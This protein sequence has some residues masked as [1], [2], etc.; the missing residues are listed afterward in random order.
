MQIGKHLCSLLLISFFILLPFC[1]KIHIICSRV[2]EL[3]AENPELKS[4]GGDEQNNKN[5][6][7]AL[8]CSSNVSFL[9][10]VYRLAYNSTAE[11]NQHF[12]SYTTFQIN[13]H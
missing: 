2:K 9:N 5:N 1:K 11:L 8:L 12:L 10:D 3:G 7:L 13:I 4:A 6:D